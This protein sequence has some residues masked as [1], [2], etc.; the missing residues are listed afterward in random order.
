M[1]SERKVVV[2]TGASRGINTIPGMPRINHDQYD[3]DGIRVERFTTAPKDEAQRPPRSSSN[4]YSQ[5]AMP[6]AARLVRISTNPRYKCAR[7]WSGTDDKALVNFASTATKAA[8]GSG[9]KKSP[10][11]SSSTRA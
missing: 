2:I 4:A 5:L 7:A 3:I 8:I 9:A 10:P 1:T 11:S 6:S